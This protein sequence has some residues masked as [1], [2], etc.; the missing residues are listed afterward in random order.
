M[1]K[2][3]TK[4]ELEQKKELARMYYM[5]GD[6][7]KVIAEKV[8]V[9]EQTI[10]RWVEIEGWAARR[11]GINITRPELINKSLAALNKILDQVYES[12]DID[13]I[14]TLPDKLS[15][16]ASAI[17]KLDKKANI[18]TTIDVFMAFSKWI[19]HRATFDPEVTP[20]LIRAINKYQD[21]YITEHLTKM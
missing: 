12:D 1:A 9:S 5:N 13:M 14:S 19:Q 15:K 2:R 10:S 11:A 8:G 6:I 17:E 7:Q 4:K 16:F 18:V 20:E 21:M 3:A